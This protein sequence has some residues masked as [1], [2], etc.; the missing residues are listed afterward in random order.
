MS[1]DIWSGNEATPLA[2]EQPQ[3]WADLE[4]L[5]RTVVLAAHRRSVPVTGALD[6]HG[7]ETGWTVE[8]T[9]L[10]VERDGSR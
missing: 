3:S 10:A 8:I 7:D 2:G 1:D 4:R 9:E 6:V 5:I